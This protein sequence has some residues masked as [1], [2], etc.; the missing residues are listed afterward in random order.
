MSNRSIHI[1]GEGEAAIG[2]ATSPLRS[3]RRLGSFNFSEIL[4]VQ[5]LGSADV[6]GAGLFSAVESPEMHLNA[7]VFNDRAPSAVRLRGYALEAVLHVPLHAPIPEAFDIRHRP[8]VGRTIVPNVTVDVIDDT[9]DFGETDPAFERENDPVNEIVLPH[10]VHGQSIA[11]TGRTN[12]LAG[13]SRVESLA[14]AVSR[15]M[16]HGP[17]SPDENTSVLI[18]VEALSQEFEVEGFDILNAANTVHF[19]NSKILQFQAVSRRPLQGLEASGSI[20]CFEPIGLLAIKL[21]A[22]WS[23]PRLSCWRQGGEAPA[24]SHHHGLEREEDRPW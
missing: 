19:D 9:W 22:E 7:M 21:V 16:A 3:G 11:V 8:H 20:D 4:T 15:E 18:E 12:S 23:L 13:E 24:A 5:D 17:F 6:C 14:K 2:V 10:K 1:D